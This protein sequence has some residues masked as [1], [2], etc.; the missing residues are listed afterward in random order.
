MDNT[1]KQ[2]HIQ[3]YIYTFHIKTFD[4]GTGTAGRPGWG[5]YRKESIFTFQGK[6]KKLLWMKRTSHLCDS[7]LILNYQYH[8]HRTQF[9][10]WP[11][12]RQDTE[13]AVSPLSQTGVTVN[14]AKNLSFTFRLLHGFGANKT[15]RLLLRTTFNDSSDEAQIHAQQR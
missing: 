1:H 13:P 9:I 5:A 15:P 14:L 4:S 3:T 2:E 11:A 7:T 12:K 10:A 8:K 6:I